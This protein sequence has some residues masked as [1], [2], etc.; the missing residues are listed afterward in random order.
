MYSLPHILQ[1]HYWGIPELRESSLE[2]ETTDQLTHLTELYNATENEL[3]AAQELDSKMAELEKALI[4]T[5]ELVLIL[6]NDLQ[7]KKQKKFILDLI[8]IKKT[9][10]NVLE[11][12]VLK[13][14]VSLEQAT[15][16]T[17]SLACQSLAIDFEIDEAPT[18]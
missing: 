6:K 14:K 18:H 5:R 10:I 3:C 17:T 15:S 7:V 1:D 9:E 12:E 16:K 4:E 11:E 8:R 2:D 13:R